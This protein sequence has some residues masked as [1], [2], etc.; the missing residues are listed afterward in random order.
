MK[1]K[2]S[3]KLI[4]PIGGVIFFGI[5]ISSIFAS[6]NVIQQSK[7]AALEKINEGANRYALM[8][9]K[10]I[11]GSFKIAR[12]VSD[13]FV[14]LKKD[15]IVDRI[16]Y[17]DIL[18]SV[19]AGNPE[20]LGIFTIWEPNALDGKDGEFANSA[21]HDKTGR[22]IPYWSNFSRN[23]DGTS[24][25]YGGYADLDKPDLYAEIKNSLKPNIRQPYKMDF[26][27]LK[28]SIF[29]TV[30][31]PII[32]SDKNFYGIVGIDIYLDKWQ[33]IFKNATFIK[34]AEISVIDE[35]GNYVTN[36]DKS[37][38]NKKAE[39]YNESVKKILNENKT[40]IFKY[41]T[42]NNIKMQTFFV[43][44][45]IEDGI[46]KWA[47]SVSIPEKE[48]YSN[49]VNL[50][51]ILFIINSIIVIISIVL[52]YLLIKMILHPVKKV[53]DTL[54]DIAEKDGNLTIRINTD[55]NDE[56]GEMADN[57]N[58]FISKIENMILQVKKVV[59]I[60]IEEDK[61][62]E[63]DM[64]SIV[65][66]DYNEKNVINLKEHIVNV[67]DNVR[68]QTA[69]VQE[70]LAGLEEINR[71]GKEI[72]DASKTSGINSKESVQLGENG[73]KNMQN[74]AEGME[75]IT[76]SV[77]QANLQIEKLKSLSD[78]IGQ[79][80]EAIRGIAEQTNLLA[81]NA[82]IEAARAGEAGRGFAVV[83]TEIRKLAEQ[84]NE[85][86]EKIS[87][88]V[89]N[90]QNEVQGVYSANKK[91]AND[92]RVG[93]E[94]TQEVKN[95]IT[96]II[97]I[98]KKTDKKIDEVILATEKQAVATD[99]ITKA[100]GN[101]SENSINIESMGIETDEIGNYIKDVLVKRMEN[102]IKLSEN[103][104]KLKEDIDYFKTK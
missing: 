33:N 37:K 82:A 96:S 59:E 86:T 17:N 97:E 42:K 77:K 70:T 25:T 93:Y 14:G 64:R 13:T 48:I 2:I 92:V 35:N 20:L 84:T 91:V 34:N 5:L 60:V 74:A 69:S 28:E 21:G 67:L 45:L 12:T 99:E 39:N 52:M 41:K 40:Y 18:K 66:N 76:E 68:N 55:S 75:K 78:N 19:I 89:G 79:I 101:I 1:Q 38:I 61:I 90:I 65:S 87:E 80:I 53:T 26:D 104:K 4:I 71:I 31:V 3:Q 54:Q 8:A 62:I 27:G 57:L 46:S 81:L 102:I 44:F 94:L 23:A 29:T 56:I 100:V 36:M 10:E 63:N 7:K 83:A 95:D 24:Y 9:Q 22:F 16:T 11:S 58:I 85:E 51:I 32:D 6:Y 50:F 72:V 15:G 49:G 98:S 88:I 103:V 47:L 43:P 73:V 30:I